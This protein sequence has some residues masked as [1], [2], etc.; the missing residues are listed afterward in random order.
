MRRV[1]QR[2][3]EAAP[4]LS[5]P[6]HILVID[7]GGTN[8]KISAT[9][10][11]EVRPTPSGRKLTAAR[12]V[13]RVLELAGD[14]DYDAVAIGYPG[15]VG[16]AGPAREP[17][18][19]GPGWVGF[20][21][22]AAF[23]KPVRIINDAAMQALGSY[24]GGRMLFL[25]LG[26]SLG[27][28]LISGRSILPLELGHLPF[29]RSR[30]E[31]WLSKRGRRKYGKRR[32]ERAVYRAAEMLHQAFAVDYVMFGGGNAKKLRD[33]PHGCRVGGNR[34]A[35]VGGYRLWNLELP[36]VKP[37]GPPRGEPRARRAEWRVV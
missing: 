28:T 15:I 9:G 32:W 11:T 10:Q 5:R 1:A 27:S 37:L 31:D 13:E 29:R 16:P 20:D 22:A 25:G 21:F 23:G 3:G 8:V 12:M 17:L 26:T 19:L 6:K 7:I 36:G 34:N 2:N 18:N 33:V 30:L 4:R 35:F 14:W 24:L